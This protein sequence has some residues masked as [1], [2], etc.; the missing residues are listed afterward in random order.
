MNATLS[1]SLSKLH[2]AWFPVKLKTMGINKD[3]AQIFG[4]MPSCDVIWSQCLHTFDWKVDPEYRVQ[5][6]H[7]SEKLRAELIHQ[8]GHFIQF[9]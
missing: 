3:A 9:L 7:L 4:M 6:S 1:C 5:P 8:S 2:L